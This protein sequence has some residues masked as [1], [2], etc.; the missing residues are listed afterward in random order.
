MVDELALLVI[1]E[2]FGHGTRLFEG[3]GAGRHLD[4]VETRLMD[5]GA[6]QMRY[7]VRPR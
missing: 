7:R 4:L 3:H 1:P 5:T 2:I 6:M